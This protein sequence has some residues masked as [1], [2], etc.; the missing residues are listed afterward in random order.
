MT[1]SCAVYSNAILFEDLS[2]AITLRREMLEAIDDKLRESSMNDHH[3]W[4]S[5]TV[6]GSPMPNSLPVAQRMKF[7]EDSD[8]DDGDP[9]AN[10][11]M[12]W[13]SV[14]SRYRTET[15]DAATLAA[16]QIDS[17]PDHWTVVSISV[18]DDENTLLISRQQPH[19]E[20][21]VFCLPLDRHSRREGEDEEAQ[22]T[23]AKAIEE[24]EDIIRVNDETARDA[25]DITTKEGRAA[26]WSQ[27]SQLDAR[28]KELVE[29]IE[30]CWLGAFKVRLLEQSMLLGP[31]P[32]PEGGASSAANS[33]TRNSQCLP[34]ENGKS[35][36]AQRCS[37]ERQKRP[38]QRSARRRNPEMFLIAV[39]KMPR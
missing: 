18:T 16:P 8:D 36:Q 4:P 34:P 26:W 15:I 12:Y 3:A 13:Q 10:L 11:R 35:V 5:M 31:H 17:I 2:G 6:N 28:L 38:N 37:W 14:K 20:P 1:K 7:V 39:P 19:C 33:A 29:N 22:F 30:Y 9:E 23:Y 21:V 32:T 24:F 25:K 27:R